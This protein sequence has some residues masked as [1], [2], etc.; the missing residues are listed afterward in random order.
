MS[1]LLS[2]LVLPSFP[3]QPVSSGW[4]STFDSNNNSAA[5]ASSYVQDEI[6]NIL[7][8]TKLREEVYNRLE[9]DLLKKNFSRFRL[10]ANKDEGIYCSK[11]STASMASLAAASEHYLL[12]AGCGMSSVEAVDGRRRADGCRQAR[13]P[14][15]RPDWSLAVAI[16]D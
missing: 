3:Q 7:L 2:S 8:L 12:P 10:Y 1:S 14:L 16:S 6:P 4:G 9:I 15:R 11:L 13:R 5:A